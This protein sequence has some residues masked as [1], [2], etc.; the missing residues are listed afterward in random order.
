MEILYILNY[1]AKS[2]WVLAGCSTD[3]PLFFSHFLA[4]RS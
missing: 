2:L 3:F 4:R 1:Q